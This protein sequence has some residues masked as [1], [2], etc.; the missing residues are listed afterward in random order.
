MEDIKIALK[1][2]NENK[3]V[4][5]YFTEERSDEDILKELWLDA[6]LFCL[7]I[8]NSKLTLSDK[9]KYREKNLNTLILTFSKRIKGL[10]E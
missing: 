5:F 3:W 9:S 7:G 10:D 6:S 4:N 1:P 2:L 8:S